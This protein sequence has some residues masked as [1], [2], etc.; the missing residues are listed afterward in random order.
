[1]IQ[2]DIDLVH[3]EVWRKLTAT[4]GVAVAG[5]ATDA[6]SV[7]PQSLVSRIIVVTGVVTGVVVARVVAIVMRGVSVQAID[8]DRGY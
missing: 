4:R 6:T 2:F 5:G 8:V 3:Y 1:M 7:V